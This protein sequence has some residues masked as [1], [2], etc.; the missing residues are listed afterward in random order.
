M[1]TRLVV[2]RD[3]FPDVAVQWTNSAG[4]VHTV[5][6]VNELVSIVW[7][8]PIRC[9]ERDVL[10]NG[11]LHVTQATPTSSGVYT[12]RLS[13]QYATVDAMATVIVSGI[14]V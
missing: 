5:S 11:S 8:V 12:C 7:V 13:N 4:K 1:S 10:G 3:D 2:Q 14:Q 9:G 6:R